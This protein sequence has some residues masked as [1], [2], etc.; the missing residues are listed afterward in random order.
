MLHRRTTNLRR[1]RSFSGI[2]KIMY[3]RERQL[4][5]PA[6]N[7]KI[8]KKSPSTGGNLPLSLLLLYSMENT[9]KLMKTKKRRTKKGIMVR[10]GFG[11]I[12]RGMEGGGHGFLKAMRST[13]SNYGQFRRR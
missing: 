13:R 5:G 12:E 7:S 1:I 4:L 10:L 9:N 6:G 3:Q 8:K 11:W 2:K